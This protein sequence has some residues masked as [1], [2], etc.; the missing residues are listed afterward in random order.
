[1]D[2]SVLNKIL[3]QE[4]DLLKQQQKIADDIRFLQEFKKRFFAEQGEI[5]KTDTPKI[6][7]APTNFAAFKAV[8]RKYRRGSQVTVADKV[9]ESLTAINQGMLQDVA[10][11]Y[12]DLYPKIGK[13]KAYLDAKYQLSKLYRDG[14]I[15]GKKVKGKK[16]YMYSPI[17]FEVNKSVDAIQT[18][19]P[20]EATQ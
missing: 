15:N 3:A 19:L 9:I 1:M 2:K 5:E 20:E 4:A 13:E 7:H 18:S 10:N 11:K 14:L 16:G 6:K 12:F 17:K 8:K